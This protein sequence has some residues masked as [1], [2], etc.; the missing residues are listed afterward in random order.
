MIVEILASASGSDRIGVLIQSAS[1]SLSPRL[2]LQRQI[3]TAAGRERVGLVEHRHQVRITRV[4]IGDEIRRKMQ[5]AIGE[6]LRAPHESHAAQRKLA[7][8]D[9]VAALGAAHS[10][11]HVLLAGFT[12]H[13]VPFAE[14]AEPPAE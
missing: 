5:C 11:R 4:E 12:H 13:R 7:E 1:G 9:G 10:N 2:G 6:T 14:H 8:V 3:E